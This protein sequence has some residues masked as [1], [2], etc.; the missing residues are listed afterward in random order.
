MRVVLIGPP[1]AGKGTQAK[2]IAEEFG[3]PQISTGDIFRKHVTAHTELGMRAKKYMDAGD[4]VP[5]EVTIAM[6]RERLAEPDAAS[7]F[8]LDGFPRTVPQAEALRGIL[9][10]LDRPLRAVLELTLDEE[11][12][13]RRLSG[14]RTCRACGHVW[15]VDFEPPTE[16]GICDACGGELFQRDDDQPDTIRRRLQVYTEQT[17]PLVDYYATAGLVVSIAASGQVDEVTERAITALR[18]AHPEP[19]A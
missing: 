14:R 2:F 12:V 5:D 11:E 7:G 18:A 19:A 15:H 6:V 3:I 16:A 4:L 13:V 1:G 17:E 9:E 8:L 10:E